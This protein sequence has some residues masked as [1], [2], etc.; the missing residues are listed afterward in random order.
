M[1]DLGDDRIRTTT[2]IDD[3]LVLRKTA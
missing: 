3:E 1:T 2:I